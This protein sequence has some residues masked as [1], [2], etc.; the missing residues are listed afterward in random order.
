MILPPLLPA[1]A[2]RKEKLFSPQRE[3]NS[4]SGKVIAITE[5]EWNLQYTMIYTICSYL[6]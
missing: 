1:M 6:H 4:G 3:Y 5:Y 2:Y